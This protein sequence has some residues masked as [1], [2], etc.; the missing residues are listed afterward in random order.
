MIILEI[1]GGTA[2]ALAATHEGIMRNLLEEV[3]PF[4]DADTLGLLEYLILDED[5]VSLSAYMNKVLVDEN[6]AVENSILTLNAAAPTN[7]LMNEMLQNF[8]A[9]KQEASVMY[10]EKYGLLA[11]D[12]DKKI[13]REEIRIEDDESEESR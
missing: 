3:G 6:E 5:V 9:K 8:D 2:L 10:L 11:V 12:V 7:K 13:I 1:L 4:I